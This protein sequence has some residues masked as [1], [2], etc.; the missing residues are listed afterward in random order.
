[1]DWLRFL[2]SPSDTT[3]EEGIIVGKSIGGIVSF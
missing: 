2:P 1:M 3:A